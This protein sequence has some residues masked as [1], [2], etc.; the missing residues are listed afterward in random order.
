MTTSERSSMTVLQ[1]L[2]GVIRPFF[3]GRALCAYPILLICVL[4]EVL[5]QWATLSY[6]QQ[7]APP[8]VPKFPVLGVSLF[9][10]IILILEMF[11]L[12]MAVWGASIAGWRRVFC[13]FVILILCILTWATIKDIGYNDSNAALASSRAKASEAERLQED[14]EVLDRRLVALK[15]ND[16]LTRETL[17]QEATRLSETL[18][19]LER[20]IASE[21]ERY[22][23]LREQI[24]ERAIDPGIR[25]EI[26]GLEDSLRARGEQYKTDVASLQQQLESARNR[27][28]ELIQ[29]AANAGSAELTAWIRQCE[30]ID[31]NHRQLLV[32]ASADH[33]KAIA[34]YRERLEA[35]SKRRAEFEQKRLE[36]EADYE[37]R[38]AEHRKNDGP[39]YNLDSELRKERVRADRDIARLIQEFEREPRPTEPVKIVPPLPT[40]PPRP[41]SSNSIVGVIDTR[42][43]ETRIAE[44]RAERDAFIASQQ[45]QI[46]TLRQRSSERTSAAQAQLNSELAELQQRHQAAMARIT[47]DRDA[48]RRAAEQANT[49]RDAANM[50]PLAIQ[51]EI[52]SIPEQQQQLSLKINQLKQ[53]SEQEML[54]SY[55]GRMA[56]FMSYF[57]GDRTQEERIA[58]ILTFFIP[59]LALVMSFAPP[60]VLEAVL[61]GLILD[62]SRDLPKRK[63]SIWMRLQ[64]GRRALRRERGILAARQLA[65]DDQTRRQQ[66]REAQLSV[67]IE[68][69]AQERLAALQRERDEARDALA[70]TA[71]TLER[72]VA[73]Q[74]ETHETAIELVSKQRDDITKLANTVIEFDTRLSGSGE[75]KS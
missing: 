44:L 60:I 36:V 28:T 52:L 5:V 30:Q 67:E 70:A 35:F 73:T 7:S 13:N 15:S 6:E 54:D 49:T 29:A 64:L 72:I 55:P 25:E 18:D 65:L 59:A 17:A 14:L 37:R 33:D 51:R 32:Q 56:Q 3:S 4:A 22:G 39:F 47:A 42:E 61:H 43:L 24:K 1:S 75:A 48:A 12:P 8:N 69:R 58:V 21:I 9:G 2:F 62:R 46:A 20:E 40:K 45:Q 66:E 38:C 27:N 11:K 68:E 31:E 63:R 71:V 23:R 26:A 16:E 10:M 53:Q 50:D 74:R 19:R 41:E 34:L 57:M